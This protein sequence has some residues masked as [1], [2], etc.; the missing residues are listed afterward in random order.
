MN[1]ILTYSKKNAS[2]VVEGGVVADNVSLLQEKLEEILQSDAKKLAIDMSA[3]AMISSIGIGKMVSFY[4]DFIQKKGQI[5]MITCSKEI[6]NLF[7]V[8]KLNQLI[9]LETAKED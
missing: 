9:R 4:N 1:V 8:I 6:Y 5:E 2:L 3:C 7:S